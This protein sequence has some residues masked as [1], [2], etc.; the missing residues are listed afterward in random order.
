MKTAHN[1]KTP[2]QKRQMILDSYTKQG[3]V[4]NFWEW[5]KLTQGL[6]VVK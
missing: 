4:I 1:S 3:Y 5:D 2:E 6:I